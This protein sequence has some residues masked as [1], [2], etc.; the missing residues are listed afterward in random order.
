MQGSH[1]DD[2]HDADAGV[3]SQGLVLSQGAV[4]V[5]SQGKRRGAAVRS[6][7]EQ[8]KRFKGGGYGRMA[9]MRCE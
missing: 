9:A 1:D 8:V 6:P 3:P 4:V 7:I 2:L 5:C